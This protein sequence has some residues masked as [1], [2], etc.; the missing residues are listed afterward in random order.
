[1]PR[2]ETQIFSL[3]MMDV[4]SGAMGAFLIIMIVL[5]RYYK[6]DE[7]IAAQRKQVQQQ[8][9]EL[10]RQIDEAIQQL[11]MTTDIDVED[12]LR[13]FQL[14]Q[15][16]LARARQEVNQLSNDLQAARNRVDQLQIEKD[17]LDRENWDLADQLVFRKP[18]MVCAKWWASTSVNVGLYLES[19]KET[20]DGR[21]FLFNPDVPQNREYKGDFQMTGIG[22]NNFETWI[23]RDSYAGATFKI[24]VALHE[25]EAQLAPAEIQVYAA[26]DGLW[27]EYDRFEL[28]AD[29]RWELAG[30][31]TTDDT[32]KTTARKVTESERRED[33]RKVEL[34]MRQQKRK[35][36][37]N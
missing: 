9:E 21:R 2:R 6:E 18:F 11:Q 31:L 27:L 1:M 5:M 12:L 32:G 23:V 24:Y 17:R 33:R 29:K 15:R 13:R 7:D 28:N 16:Q 3:S 10:R 36:K 34:R 19:S 25:E 20:T 30:I 35:P 26:G 4:I 22:K 37:G 8:M 14:M